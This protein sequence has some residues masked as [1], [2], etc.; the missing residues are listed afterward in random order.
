[1]IYMFTSSTCRWTRVG[2][3]GLLACLLAPGSASAESIVNSKH[4]LSVTGPG[5]VRAVTET[6]ICIFCHTPHNATREAPLWNRNSSGAAYTPYSSTTAKAN[7][8]QPT[9]ASRLCLSCHDGTV[10][11]GMVRSRA[12]PIPFEG[13]VFNMPPGSARLGT[14]LGDDHPVSFRYDIQLAVENGQLMNPAS[15]TT[16][17]RLDRQEELQCTSCHDPHDDQYGMFLVRDNYASGLCLT[18]HDPTY[19]DASVHRN[20]DATWNGIGSDPW[21]RSELATVS[22][23][24][25]G[26][27]HQS[28]TAG[29]RER[30]LRYAGEEVNCYVCHNGNVSDHNIQSEFGKF[31]VHDV[32]RTIGVHDPTE[33][34]VNS[35]RHVECADCHNAHAVTMEDAAP[36]A[37]SGALKGVTGIN[38][39]GTIVSPIQNDYELCFRCHADSL[40]RGPS[41]IPRQFPETN[42]RLEFASGNA[43]FHPVTTIGRNPDVPSLISPYTTSSMIS[44]MDCHN[45]DQG[46]GAG[47]AGPNGPHGSAYPPLLERRLE[48]D[49]GFSETSG[50]YALCYKCH[51]RQSILDDESFGEHK[52]HIEDGLACTSC[53]DPHGVANKTHL[54]NFNTK[55]VRPYNGTI[56]FVDEGRFAGNCTLTCHGEEHD[57]ES[58]PED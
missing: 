13:G 53:H 48:L 45:N 24:A 6:Q 52:K 7:I 17:V 21:P 9:G 25:C 46:P 8:G 41:R 33:D 34:L 4:N 55:Y 43:S 12:E 22:A 2:L 57:R 30:L 16:D 23:N 3:L 58:Y 1:M 20:A 32:E 31:S 15:L 11:L 50:L 56:E 38:T 28:H 39:S 51:S 40:E 44:C 29:G 47:G 37:A 14:D 19:W 18:C 35:P 26:N 54:I 27:C 10:A 49:D 5:T 42:T 36:P